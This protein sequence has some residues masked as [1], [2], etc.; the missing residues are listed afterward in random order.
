MRDGVQTRF[1][2][3]PPGLF[4]FVLAPLLVSACSSASR[5]EENI[6]QPVVL[7]LDPG[8]KATGLAL[9]RCVC[10]SIVVFYHYFNPLILPLWC[11]GG[12]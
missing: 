5:V 6:G 8:S 2:K 7:K 4:F 9:A 11:K 1:T 3:R 12:F 10:L